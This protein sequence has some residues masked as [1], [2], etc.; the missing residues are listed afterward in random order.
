MDKKLG[1]ILVIIGALIVVSTLE[2]VKKMFSLNL[3]FSDALVSVVGVIIFLIGVFL[4]RGGKAKQNSEVP[5]YHGK[6]I[7]GYR[8][9]K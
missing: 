2:L 4:L 8:R 3:G 1:Y 9:V 5:I 6:N 7:V